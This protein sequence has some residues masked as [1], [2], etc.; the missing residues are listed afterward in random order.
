MSLL[1]TLQRPLQDLRISVTD[2][3]NFRCSYCMP[4]H[5]FGESY[6]FLPHPQL[7]TYEEIARF[8]R[9]SVAQGVRKLRLTG[10][11]PLVRQ[12]L[13]Q[14]IALLAPIEGVDD[15]AMTT[16]GFLLARY[17]PALA[18]AGLKRVTVSLD[19]LDNDVFR[20]MNGGKADVAP[21]LE[22]IQAAVKAGMTPLKINAVVKKGVNDHTLVDL[23]RFCKDNGYTLRLIEFMDV[24]TRNQWRM[25][26]V[27]TAQ[28]MI[29][30]I[31]SVMPLERLPADYYGE[32]AYRYR[33]QDGAGEIGVIAS[34]SQPF[35]G[36]CTRLRLSPDGQLFTCLFAT[37]GTS[38]REMLRDGSSD[39]AITQALG[40]VWRKRTDRYSETRT[41]AEA[42]NT[43]KI[44]MY[45]IGG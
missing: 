11:E 19:S 27:V 26:H 4:A 40:R 20:A 38:V 34:V 41:P 9:I 8:A 22:G 5:I 43:K 21:V 36:T 28:A 6:Q 23:A 7:L 37:K 2:R 24:G 10:G 14:L 16:N 35:C 15:I 18:D 30:A 12:D 13:H 29:E 31:D 44:E 1:D 3:C 39:E 25:E 17:A 45:Y 33:Y 42:E 32:V